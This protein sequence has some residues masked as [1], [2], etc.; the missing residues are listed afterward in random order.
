MHET[1]IAHRFIEEA[2]RHG[3]VLSI[4]IEVGEVAHITKD[5]LE[6]VLKTLVN[7]NVTIIEIPA[8]A[9]CSCGYKGPPKIL[10]RGHDFCLYE[11]PQCSAVPTITKGKDMI[12]KSVEIAS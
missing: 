4:T 12:L 10:E 5:E 11:C 9:E 6:P 2:K 3:K 1:V 8:M 7:W